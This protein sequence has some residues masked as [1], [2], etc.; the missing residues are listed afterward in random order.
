M[1]AFNPIF[2]DALAKDLTE[3]LNPDKYF[4]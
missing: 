4:V 3:N 2:E 1:E